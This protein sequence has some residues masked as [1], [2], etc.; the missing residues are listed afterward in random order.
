M[1]M[2]HKDNE[3]KIP[4]NENRNLLDDTQ[5]KVIDET[6]KKNDNNEKS[7]LDDQTGQLKETC[8]VSHRLRSSASQYR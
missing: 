6:V 2:S 7:T 1:V 3:H 5:I 8:T 4:I